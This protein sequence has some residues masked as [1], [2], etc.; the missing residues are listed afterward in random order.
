MVAAFGF[1][2]VG[3]LLLTSGSRNVAVAELL[4]GVLSTGGPGPGDRGFG[5]ALLDEFTGAGGAPGLAGPIGAMA[6]FDG[7][8]V[9]GWVA[10]EL[11]VARRN[12]WGGQLLSGYR[13]NAEQEEAC[14]GTSGPCAKPGESN[15]QGRAFPSCAADVSDPAG[16]ARALPAG[17]RLKWTGRTIGDAPHFSSGRSGV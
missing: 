3:W 6:T 12:G 11:E 15:H 17:S 4:R 2:L 14:A 13:T 10:A 9:C 7:H 5:T 8:P 1:L 16:L